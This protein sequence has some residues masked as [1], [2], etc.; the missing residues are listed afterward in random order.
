MQELM[1]KIDFVRSLSKILGQYIDNVSSLDYKV[2]KS[3]KEGYID[4]YLVINFK[5][6]G[7]LARNSNYNSKIAILRE[8]AKLCVGGYYEEVNDYK[9][10]FNEDIWEEIKAAPKLVLLVNC[11]YDKIGELIQSLTEIKDCHESVAGVVQDYFKE[12][13]KNNG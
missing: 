8:I 7:F 3:K 4:E 10:H 1:E 11:K 9:K 12:K 13:E 2:F 6:N 5:G